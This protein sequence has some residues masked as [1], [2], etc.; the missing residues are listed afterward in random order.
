MGDIRFRLSQPSFP[1]EPN[2]GFESYQDIV[3]LAYHLKDQNKFDEL[4]YLLTAN[5]NL[6]RSFYQSARTEFLIALYYQNQDLQNSTPM[7]LQ[8]DDPLGEAANHFKL[9]AEAAARIPDWPLHAELKFRESGACYGSYPLRKRYLRAF[10]AA[11]EALRAWRKAPVVNNPNYIEYE[12]NLADALGGCAYFVAKD[13]VA[14]TAFNRAAVLL[15]R[16]H[17]HDDVDPAKYQKDSFFLHWDWAAVLQSI[18]DYARALKRALKARDLSDDSPDLRNYGRVNAIIAEIAL[19][20]LDGGI[21]WRGYTPPRLLAIADE[22]SEKALAASRAAGDQAGYTLAQ[23]VRARFLRMKERDAK[24][25]K[26]ERLG[27]LEEAL[28]YATSIASKDPLLLGRVEI[29]WGDEYAWRNLQRHSNKSL[30]KAREFYQKA[31]ERLTDVQAFGVARIALKRLEG[32][33]PPEPGRPR[34]PPR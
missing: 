31:A 15:Q 6:R 20:C 3:D 33:P 21:V 4:F 19:D 34:Q 18:G 28:A 7:D 12:F 5:S 26:K 1:D 2:K 25:A 10:A 14:V 17:K 22:A 11:E 30:E 27:M 29:A 24:E 16:F 23:L 9:G 13:E 8:E 32:L